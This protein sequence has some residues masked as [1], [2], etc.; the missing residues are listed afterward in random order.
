MAPCYQPGLICHD[1]PQAIGL[2]QD[3]QQDNKDTA[4]TTTTTTTTRRRGPGGVIDATASAQ[5][6][7]A[8][9]SMKVK[10]RYSVPN[11]G[12]E[13]ARRGGVQWLPSAATVINLEPPE[14]RLDG[15]AKPRQVIMFV[16][17]LLFAAVAQLA[18]AQQPSWDVLVEFGTNFS[19]LALDTQNEISELYEFN[20]E[21]I[22][23]FNRELL[24]E[25]GRM[26]PQLRAADADFVQQIESAADGVDAE[27]VE[28]V[29]EL[30][31]LFLLFQNW[32]IQDCAYYAHAT[33]QV[34][35]VTRFLPYAITFLSENT[36]SISQVIETLG[37]RNLND[38]EGIVDELDD[39]WD[40]YQVLAVSF[41]DFLFDEILLHAPVADA[42]Y[43][44]LVECRETAVE[45]QE[46]DHEYILSYLADNCE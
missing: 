4:T 11:A 24:L 23:E 36:R 46:S 18:C 40:Y 8:A 27:C 22:R 32:D 28:Y 45:M 6:I 29:Q 21:I 25:L 41:S 44:R 1:G 34:D 33:L 7:A 26:V 19:T 38:L 15:K 17:F 31:E 20:G 10:A 13:T 37:R 3:Q 9:A 2:G 14:I 12:A 35:S 30:R 16:K 43:L 42:V 5:Q 39:E